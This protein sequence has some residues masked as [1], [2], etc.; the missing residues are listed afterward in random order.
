[1]IHGGGKIAKYGRALTGDTSVSLVHAIALA[2]DRE[3][4]TRGGRKGALTS[5]MC[6][7]L[8]YAATS[9]TRHGWEGGIDTCAA[10]AAEATKLRSNMVMSLV[11][12]P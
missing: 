11:N 5:D 10:P 1:M 12:T 4:M 3:V 2:P 7:S 6:A 8:V 9:T